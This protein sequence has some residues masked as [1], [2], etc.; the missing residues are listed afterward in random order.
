MKQLAVFKI[1][2]DTYGFV[3][4]QRQDF[5]S[6]ALPGI[7]VL[8]ILGT[9]FTLSAMVG[10]SSIVTLGGW[11]KIAVSLAV[12]VMFAVAWHRGYLVPNEATTVRATLRWGPRHTRFLLLVVGVSALVAAL[13]AGVLLPIIIVASFFVDLIGEVQHLPLAIF[14]VS[15]PMLLIYARL[16]L[17]FPST[18]VDHPMSF[19]ECWRVTC[20][21]GWRLALIISL[22]ATPVWVITF[23]ID[24]TVVPFLYFLKVSGSLIVQ[25]ALAILDTALW[26]I[27]IAVGVTAL[28]ISYRA[29]LEAPS[30]APPDEA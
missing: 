18:S 1:W 22:I 19:S 21:N 8:A 6:L 9:L 28:S 7:V 12:Q 11:V 3:W 4:R 5:L 25:F 30:D 2:R 17:L 26:F 23:L 14:I 27:G 29:L 13:A 16:S 15:V 10:L 20:G 24:L